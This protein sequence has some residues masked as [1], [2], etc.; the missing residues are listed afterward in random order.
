MTIYIHLDQ[1]KKVI[2]IF[3]VH[4]PLLCLLLI[5]DNIFNQEKINL[6]SYNSRIY[7]NIQ[8][9]LSHYVIIGLGQEKIN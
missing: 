8:L 5:Y 2:T 4:N 6:L 1:K 7:K 3:R 9:C